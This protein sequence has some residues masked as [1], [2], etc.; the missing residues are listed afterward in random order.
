M[1]R[2]WN[3][4]SPDR[5]VCVWT[6]MERWRLLCGWVS[7][8]TH[9]HTNAQAFSFHLIICNYSLESASSS[10]GHASLTQKFLILDDSVTID[11]KTPNPV[12][13]LSDR[14][15]QGPVCRSMDRLLI[16]MRYT[17]QKGNVL[18]LIERKRICSYCVI[19]CAS[20]KWNLL[21]CGIS[22][23]TDGGRGLQLNTWYTQGTLYKYSTLWYP[24]SILKALEAQ[25]PY[26]LLHLKI[27]TYLSQ[28]CRADCI[29]QARQF[30]RYSS[31]CKKNVSKNIFI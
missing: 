6:G 7:V 15:K 23:V 19:D 11:P 25:I 12:L 22:C 20:R 13:F 27:L 26:F 28:Y 29:S 1:F 14:V 18:S 30:N 24:M 9:R 21:D 31:Y 17:L 16:V 10:F 4:P 3:V 2:S 8:K 5:G